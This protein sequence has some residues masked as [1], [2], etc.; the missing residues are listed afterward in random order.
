MLKANSKLIHSET[1]LFGENKMIGWID[2]SLLVLLLK[3]KIMFKL[4]IGPLIG[5]EDTMVAFQVGAPLTTG[6]KTTHGTLKLL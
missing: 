3:S 4:V 6:T 1:K 5:Q 2:G